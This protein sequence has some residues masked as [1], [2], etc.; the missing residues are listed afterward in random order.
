MRLR[1]EGVV[2]SKGVLE[3]E[4][5]PWSEQERRAKRV[6]R[7]QRELWYE[8]PWTEEAVWPEE[9]PC[10]DAMLVVEARQRGPSWSTEVGPTTMLSSGWTA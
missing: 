6:A 1:P 4:E 7:P 2:G 3:L 8:L 9:M 5:M 10:H